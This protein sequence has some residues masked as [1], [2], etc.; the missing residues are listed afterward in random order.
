MVF[1]I[2]GRIFDIEIIAEGRGIRGIRRLQ[3]LYGAGNWRKMKGYA[4][5]RLPN[6][7]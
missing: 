4:Q 5:V 7:S 2:V 1:E 3:K 6:G